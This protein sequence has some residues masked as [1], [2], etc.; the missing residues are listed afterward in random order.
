MAQD[1]A[2]TANTVPEDQSPILALRVCRKASALPSVE[3][4]EAGSQSTPGLRRALVSAAEAPEK[5]PS[6]AGGASSAAGQPLLTVDQIEEIPSSSAADTAE[7]R[8]LAMDS[9]M[10][11]HTQKCHRIHSVP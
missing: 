5:A 2:A 9:S 7:E 6:A 11:G 3:E 8:W 4:A 1:C 10:S